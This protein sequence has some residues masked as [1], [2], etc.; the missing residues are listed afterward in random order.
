MCFYIYIYIYTHM[1]IYTHVFGEIH[2]KLPAC[3]V[4]VIETGPK[5]RGQLKR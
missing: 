2:E 4:F 5:L 3:T 1:P